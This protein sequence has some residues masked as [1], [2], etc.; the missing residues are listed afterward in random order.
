[1]K[2]ERRA[3]LQ[4]IFSHLLPPDIAIYVARKALDDP[5]DLGG[6]VRVSIVG[7]ARLA[8]RERALDGDC[9]DEPFGGDGTESEDAPVHDLGPLGGGAQ[10]HRREAEDRGFLGQRAGI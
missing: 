3:Q 7:H 8:P 10:A 4:E 9:L 1:M 5:R 2:E 6:R